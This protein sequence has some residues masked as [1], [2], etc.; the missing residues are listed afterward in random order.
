MLRTLRGEITWVVCNCK[1]LLTGS[2]RV[3]VLVGDATMEVRDWS[4]AKKGP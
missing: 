1:V 3:R 2:R 4:D